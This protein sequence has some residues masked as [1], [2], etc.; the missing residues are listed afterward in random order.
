MNKTLW[1]LPPVF[2]ALFACETAKDT[3]NDANSAQDSANRKV[4]E[5]NAAANQEI[6]LAQAKADRGIAEANAGFQK[7][8]EDFRHEMT[9]HLAKLDETLAKADAKLAT[10]K[11]ATRAKIAAEIPVVRAERDKF[12]KKF[13]ETKDATATTWD[14]VAASLKEDWSHLEALAERID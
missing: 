10:Q 1:I 12:A 8:R 7:L 3:Q 14:A 6:V 5:V 13:E 9:A 2:L 4:A 11:G